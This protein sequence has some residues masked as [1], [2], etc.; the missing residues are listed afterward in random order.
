MAPRSSGTRI[1]RNA[2]VMTHTA[3]SGG[4]FDTGF[5]GPG[6]SSAPITM[7]TVG[8]FPYLCT[9]HPGMT[10]TLRVTP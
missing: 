1:W 4:T 2:D 10:G 9:L 8:T 6:A 5:V 3:T 7:S